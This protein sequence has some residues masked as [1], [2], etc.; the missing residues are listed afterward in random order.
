MKGSKGLLI[1]RRGIVAIAA[2][3]GTA[4]MGLTAVALGGAG[5]GAY[6]PLELTFGP[7]TWYCVF[8]WPVLV[9]SANARSRWIRLCAKYATAFYYVWTF[10]V[11]YHDVLNLPH[12]LGNAGRAEPLV[13]ITWSIAFVLVNS[14]IWIPSALAHSH[15]TEPKQNLHLTRQP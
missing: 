2:V 9:I 15:M 12:E 10:C 13:M 11:F 3:I 6:G 4:C 7:L 5:H 1:P 8:L 14:L